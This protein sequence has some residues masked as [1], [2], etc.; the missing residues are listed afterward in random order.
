MPWQIL[1]CP[2]L[3]FAQSLKHFNFIHASDYFIPEIWMNHKTG[4]PFAVQRKTKQN[5]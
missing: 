4:C 1:R 2:A 5:L 3:R